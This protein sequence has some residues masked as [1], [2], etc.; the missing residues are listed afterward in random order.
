MADRYDVAV[1]GA[2]VAGLTAALWSAR[3]NLR[4][5]VID[6]M[7]PGGQ[8]MNAGELNS[9]AGLPSGVHGPDFIGRLTEQVVERPVSMEFATVEK[10]GR[11][12]DGFVV[13]SD[14]GPFAS[15]AVIVATGAL[16]RRLGVEG[17]D[18][19]EGRGVSHCAVCD[20]PGF[21]GRDV[22]VVGGGDS[23]LEAAA[24]LATLCPSVVLVHRGGK[25]GGLA[26]L[27]S[28]VEDSSVQVMLDAQVVTIV[29]DRTV[30]GVRIRSRGVE[31]DLQVA[32]VFVEIGSDPDGQIAAGLAEIDASGAIVVDEN[33]MTSTPGLFAAGAVRS[34]HRGQLASAVGEGVDVALAAGEWLAAR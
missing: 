6:S 33:G 34:R 29:G 4:T 13:E 19:Y 28:T 18:L 10:I 21:A 25:L 8:L 7:G 2:G 15:K 16:A 17:E 20:G 30:T 23:A 9:H 12:P 3:Q 31:H 5:V 11:D 1:L 14:A 22:V 27:R 32:G 26:E 24:Y